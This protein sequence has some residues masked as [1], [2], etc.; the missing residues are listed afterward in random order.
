MGPN[1]EINMLSCLRLYLDCFCDPIEKG[2]YP[3][4]GNN[5]KIFKLPKPQ[6]LVEHIFSTFH[7]Q[8]RN[9][10]ITISKTYLLG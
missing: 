9:I 3:I 7:E 10:S 4:Y 6:D 2:E 5:H 8:I 1:K